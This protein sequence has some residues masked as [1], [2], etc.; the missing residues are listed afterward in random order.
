MRPR[1]GTPLDRSYSVLAIATLA[2]LGAAPGPAQAGDLAV[3]VRGLRSSAG[4]VR[5]A[6]WRSADGFPSEDEKAA[7]RAEI[8]A[9]AGR[10]VLEFR[11]V[12]AGEVAISVFHD[13][14]GDGALDRNFLGIPREAV[15]I[16]NAAIGFTGPGD[17]EDALI[18]IDEN[19]SS[20]SLDLYHW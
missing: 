11:D 17:F 9:L 20:V 7:A 19:G 12:A 18:R 2:A 14:D 6:L 3:E 13:V 10:V 4:S 16:S 5:G 15:G 8:A 1:R